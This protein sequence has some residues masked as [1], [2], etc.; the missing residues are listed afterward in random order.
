[1]GLGEDVYLIWHSRCERDVGYELVVLGDHPV[2]LVDFD[3]DRSVRIVDPVLIEE[4]LI[5]LSAPDAA[6]SIH[7]VL[8]RVEQLA[9]EDVGHDGG[10][11]DLGVGM[12]E[13]GAGGL[14]MILEDENV[15]QLMIA[16]EVDVTFPPCVDY[17]CYLIERLMLEI[18]IVLRRLD[19]HLVGSV[20]RRHLK[21][22]HTSKV[23]LG[24]DAKRG[25]LI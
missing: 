8:L 22:P 7:V 4:E 2:A 24:K 16:F 12:T 21:H 20:S 19:R 1:M 5:Y 18:H 6:L 14:A 3:Q 23:Y 9:L 10:R 25:K 15:F 11:D 13:R 17:A